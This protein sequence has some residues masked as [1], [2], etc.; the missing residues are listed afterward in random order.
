MIKRI[1]LVC[2]SIATT[3]ASGSF[4]HL[5]DYITAMIGLPVDRIGAIADI[6]T[7]TIAFWHWR[8]TRRKEHA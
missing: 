4:H 5:N 7:G 1:E 6:G 2:V 8:H 3:V